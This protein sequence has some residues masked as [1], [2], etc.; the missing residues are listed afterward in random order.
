MEIKGIGR[1]MVEWAFSRE[2]RA[3]QWCMWIA[4]CR[5]PYK[6]II[7]NG[8]G[9]ALL[10]GATTPSAT[11]TTIGATTITSTEC[12]KKNHPKS[13]FSHKNHPKNNGINIQGCLETYGM[14]HSSSLVL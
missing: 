14:V 9:R 11:A 5:T 13:T 4:D 3:G 10:P 8:R 1:W 12:A 6:A 2:F 7:W